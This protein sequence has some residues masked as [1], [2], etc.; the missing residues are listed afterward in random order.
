MR[1]ATTRRAT[2][3]LTT[4]LL[5]GVPGGPAH[6]GRDIDFSRDGRTWAPQLTAPL[7]APEMRWVPG[8]R[9]VASFWVRNG[10]PAGAVM[11]VRAEVVG[12]LVHRGDVILR[13][14]TARTGWVE[15]GGPVSTADRGPGVGRSGSTRVDVEATF[16][17]AA[18][19]QTQ[20]EQVELGVDITL[21]A[22]RVDEGAPLPAT[23]TTVPAWL[24]VSAAAS[25]LAGAL[26]LR[27]R[28]RG[29]H[30]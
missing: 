24:L 19:N 17:P 7:F 18:T 13:A 15:L 8:D 9:R 10:G 4:V 12:D 5:V 1:A 29:H 26:L 16:D 22:D 21:T 11:R 2:A 6:A 23:G 30:G 14:R 28:R 20:E 3:L 27:R 25:L